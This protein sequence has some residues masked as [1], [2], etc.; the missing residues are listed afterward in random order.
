MPVV[1]GSETEMFLSAAPAPSTARG[2]IALSLSLS[3]KGRLFSFV[4]MRGRNSLRDES[5]S[6]S[7][8]PATSLPS[9]VTPAAVPS[10]GE[11]P[12]PAPGCMWPPG[13]LCQRLPANF[14][15]E[16]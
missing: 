16:A 6:S 7:L 12:H 4:E 9:L 2:H 5:R 14:P 15:L 8:G 10:L 3:L 13:V 1:M 11:L